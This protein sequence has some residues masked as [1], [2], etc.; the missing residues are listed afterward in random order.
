MVAADPAT[1]VITD[2]TVVATPFAPVVTLLTVCVI[3]EDA[4]SVVAVAAAA[5]RE[6]GTRSDGPFPMPARA[7]SVIAPP[8]IQR[9][10]LTSRRTLH[11]RR[12][13]RWRDGDEGILLGVGKTEEIR[14]GGGTAVP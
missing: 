11:G 6:P 13:H 4:E 7:S 12:I 14:A 9:P 3:D 8:A 5:A 10:H 2:V 1:E